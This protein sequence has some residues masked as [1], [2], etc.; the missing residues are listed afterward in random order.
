[1]GRNANRYLV[2]TNGNVWVN[3]KLLA[4]VKKVELK[5]TGSFEDMGFCGDGATYSRFTGWS[6]DGSITLQKADSMVLDLLADAFRNDAMPEIKIITKLTD[7]ATGKSERAAVEGVV[8]TE[9]MLASFEQKALVEQEIPLKF[10]GYQVLE[11]IA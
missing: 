2:G 4:D 5:V 6:G 7:T 10:S 3:G 1:M 8:F 11:T 9:I